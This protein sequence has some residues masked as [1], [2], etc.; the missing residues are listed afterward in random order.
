MMTLIYNERWAALARSLVGEGEM[1][2]ARLWYA[3]ANDGG[4]PSSVGWGSMLDCSATSAMMGSLRF[5]RGRVWR[6]MCEEGRRSCQ[7]NCSL[8]LGVNMMTLQSSGTQ[9][10]LSGVAARAS[11]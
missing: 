9:A 6:E 11:E 10:M 4:E 1:G 7:L 3:C 2:V 5:P 8:W